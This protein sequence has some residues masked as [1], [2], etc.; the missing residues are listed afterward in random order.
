MVLFTLGTGIGC[1]IIVGDLAI[2]GENGYGAECGHIVID[3]S[4]ERPDVRLR[5]A[6]PSRSLC[7]RHGRGEARPRGPGRGTG[8]FA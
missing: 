5:T 1:G 8:Q 2:D 7:Q 4:D 6:R 3:C